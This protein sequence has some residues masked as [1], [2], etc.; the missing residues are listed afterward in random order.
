LTIGTIYSTLPTEEDKE[1]FEIAVS[2]EEMAKL[3]KYVD[4]G[5][6]NVTAA[7]ITLSKMLAEGKP[8]S[9]YISESDVAGISDE[10][11]TEICR[12]AIAENP[13]VVEDFKGGKDK[14]I[15]G[16]YGFIKR[17]TQGK[18]DVRKA[19]KILRDLIG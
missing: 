7:Q 8:V 15:C 11:L 2:P 1:R 17:A 10:E 14:A 9:E 18:A 6:I 12:R 5:K 13:K 4:E 16:L 19:D 3:I